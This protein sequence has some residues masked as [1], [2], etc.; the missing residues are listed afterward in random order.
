MIWK[1]S[2]TRLKRLTVLD[3]EILDTFCDFCEFLILFGDQRSNN[4]FQFFREYSH[5]QKLLYSKSLFKEHQRVAIKV[6]PTLTLYIQQWNSINC[7]ISQSCVNFQISRHL[8]PGHAFVFCHSKLILIRYSFDIIPLLHIHWQ[9]VQKKMPRPKRK[10]ELEL[11]GICVVCGDKASS[12]KHYGSK[13]C[14]SCRAF[15]RRLANKGRVPERK[16][17]NRIVNVSGECPINIKTR[18]LCR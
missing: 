17:C 4:N 9:E 6:V 12:M 11:H 5:G 16:F 1:L 18:Q 7:G 10:K 3:R 13:V 8:P 15:F 2:K 14:F